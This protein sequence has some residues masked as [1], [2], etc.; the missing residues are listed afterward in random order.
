MR[1]E[2]QETNVEITFTSV[3]TVGKMKICM[4]HAELV[5]LSSGWRFREKKWEHQETE[6]IRDWIFPFQTNGAKEL[7]TVLLF[8]YLL[9]R[10]LF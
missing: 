1:S 6:T 7:L 10:P 2:K 5:L 4:N 9:S 8:R 3:D